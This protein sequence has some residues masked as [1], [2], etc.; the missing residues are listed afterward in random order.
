MASGIGERGV[1]Q[2]VDYQVADGIALVGL[3]HPPAN[4]LNHELRR[5]LREAIDRAVA[6]PAVRAI[7][8]TGTG[9][10]FSSGADIQE[11][12]TDAVSREPDPAVAVRSSGGLPEAAD[13]GVEWDRHGRRPRAGAG[14]GLP[15]RRRDGQALSTRG[16][17]RA[18]S[19]RG[20]HAATAAAH[21]PQGC[22]GP[23][24]HWPPSVGRARPGARLGR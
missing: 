6:D 12:G 20:R 9:A 22:A 5:G 1:T 7:V 13:H 11:F 19:G 3:R 4:A 21:R 2:L 24:R 14:R 16:N 15:D 10:M 18:D 17:S 23:H 8:V